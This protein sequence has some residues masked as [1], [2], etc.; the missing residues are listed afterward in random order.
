VDIDGFLHDI[1]RSMSPS[2]LR[3]FA[4]RIMKL[5]DSIDHDWPMEFAKSRFPIF[6]TVPEIQK[7]AIFLYLSATKEERRARV[8]ENIIGVDIISL[9]SW[10]ILLELFKKFAEGAKVST[11]SLQLISMA[12]DTTTLRIIGRL[13]A[14]GL[15]ERSQSD[16]DK[17]VTFIELTPDGVT[18]VGAVLEQLCD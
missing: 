11:K 6:S 9:P 10:N 3:E 18:K 8:R 7:D 4:A 1:E 15:V 12:P 16:T 17:R 5:A 13:E 14:S 2:G